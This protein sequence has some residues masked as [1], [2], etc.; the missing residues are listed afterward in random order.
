MGSLSR[1][2]VRP[3]GRNAGIGDLAPIEETSKDDYDR[4]IAVDQTG[5]FLGMKTA[6]AALKQSSLSAML[7]GNALKPVQE[8]GSAGRTRTGGRRHRA[9]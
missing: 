9:R 3:E 7:T 2:C 6:A 4:T 8:P 5:V 1:R